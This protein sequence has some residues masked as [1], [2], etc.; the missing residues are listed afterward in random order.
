MQGLLSK[1]VQ[2]LTRPLHHKSAD[3]TGLLLREACRKTVFMMTSY[4]GSDILHELHHLQ[5]LRD[6]KN[7]K[8]LFE[9]EIRPAIDAVLGHDISSKF[10]AL[11]PF[12]AY[13]QK[14]LKNILAQKAKHWDNL[15]RPF[16]MT[17]QSLDVMLDSSRVEFNQFQLSAHGARDLK[18]GISFMNIWQASVKRCFRS[19]MEED[20]VGNTL[21]NSG[22]V[23]LDYDDK[24]SKGLILVCPR[25]AMLWDAT[26][27]SLTVKRP[28][29]EEVCHTDI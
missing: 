29:C 9:N 14:S 12:F 15:Q 26:G 18:D 6:A 3:E 16:A 10:H 11:S 2:D 28:L 27:L 17:K 23:V 7:F 1:L 4:V 21:T 5:G 13:D 8:A 25:N 22:T 19:E 24:A 20:S